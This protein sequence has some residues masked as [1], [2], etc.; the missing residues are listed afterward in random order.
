M[1]E[2]F[3]A[4]LSRG[5]AFAAETPGGVKSVLRSRGVGAGVGWEVATT[6]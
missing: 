2:N 4:S 1:S 5:S 6:S 3:K